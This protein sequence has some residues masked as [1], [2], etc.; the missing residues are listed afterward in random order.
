M[1]YFSSIPTRTGMLSVG[2]LVGLW[3]GPGLLSAPSA[4]APSTQQ[5]TDPSARYDRAVI[6]PINDQMINDVTRDSL[7]RRVAKAREMG[8]DLIVFEL[9]TPGGMVTSAMAICSDI[10]DLSDIMTVAWV[11]PQAL[12]AGA[13]IAVSCDEI[14]LSAAG[15]I[16]DCA[17]IM[18][19]PM[20]R[21][22]TAR[23]IISI[24]SRLRRSAPT[25][26]KMTES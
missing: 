14:V 12:S 9:N 6:V 10:K 17:P 22:S 26:E 5:S 3:A 8:A 7:R 13:M 1:R 15:Q 18:M 2:L 11:H 19:N 23:S 24:W 20:P 16:G 25:L 4:T 21:S